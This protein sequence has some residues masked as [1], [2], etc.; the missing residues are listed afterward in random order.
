M[1][2]KLWGGIGN[3]LFQYAYLHN[4]LRI[5]DE[6]KLEFDTSLVIESENIIGVLN[7]CKKSVLSSSSMEERFKFRRTIMLF[8][9]ILGRLQLL[10]F[11]NLVPV[12]T[13]YE[14][15][16]REEFRFNEPRIQRMFRSVPIRG[17]F[18]NWRYVE[19][20]WPRISNEILEFLRETK[21]EKHIQEIISEKY[22]VL[23]IRG[24]DYLE[25]RMLDTFGQL[26]IDYYLEAIE[27]A[28][29]LEYKDFNVIVLTND[30][31]YA[32]NKM[33]RSIRDSA[34]FLGSTDC[35]AWEALKIMSTAEVVI[36]ANSTFS[37][38]GGFICHKLGGLTITPSP[39]FAGLPSISDESLSYPGF[40]Q[41]KS[42]F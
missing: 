29:K 12:G 32:R 16:E 7:Y 2:I 31:V 20:A 36:T 13:K 23:H 14:L 21:L 17:F 18:Q 19:I 22:L 30:I 39:W 6:L 10:N 4:Y 25:S 26:Q 28:K 34:I 9:R 42:G 41:V 1:R 37:W 15:H 11:G 27:F 8:A 35:N 40:K 5:D 3:Q 24:G 38:W 33:P